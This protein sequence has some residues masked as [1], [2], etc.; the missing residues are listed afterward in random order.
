MA[1][2]DKPNKRPASDEAI[3]QEM[4][5]EDDGSIYLSERMLREMSPETIKLLY[6]IPKAS[7]RVGW[8]LDGKPI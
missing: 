3:A 2:K 6:G 4:Y 1:K 7:Q 8:F 5:D